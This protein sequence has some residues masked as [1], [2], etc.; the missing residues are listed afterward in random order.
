MTLEV[1]ELWSQSSMLGNK[2]LSCYVGE[3]DVEIKLT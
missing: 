1:R 3:D 2:F